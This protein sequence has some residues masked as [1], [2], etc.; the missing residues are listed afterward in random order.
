ML[1]AT[2]MQFVAARTACPRKRWIK[3]SAVLVL[4]AVVSTACEREAETADPVELSIL[5]AGTAGS[6][7]PLG[8]ELARIYS[9]S[10]PGVRA[11]VRSTVGSVF[12]VMSIQRGEADIA[13]TQAD[14]AYV[15]YS[16]G[17][18][19]APTRHL[20][21]R[22]MAVLWV[23]TVQVIVRRDSSIRRF[24][25]LRGRRVAVGQKGSG[26][27]IASRTVIEGYGMTYD[28]L[29]AEYLSFA[30]VVPR[31]ADGTLDAGFVVASY[32]VNAVEDINARVGIR[33]LPIEAAVARLIRSRYPFMR[34]V[35]VPANSYAHQTSDVETV[36]IDNIL[37][38]RADLPDDL[39]YTLTKTLFESLP[40]L[41]QGDTAARLIDPEQ[42]PITPITL[43]PGAARY[44]REREIFQ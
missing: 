17:I 44:Y 9:T 13:F 10:V 18:E 14:V 25:D 21:L 42:G 20:R 12:N 35:K 27:E 37:V 33:I 40:A 28:D 26:T 1:P 8:R 39:V 2:S 15:A 4:A 29:G 6:F 43:H 34:P 24:A 36:G 11:S 41:A 7:Y 23:N 38:C 32:P 31:M 3:T 30:D 22:G 5:T 19:D 16:R